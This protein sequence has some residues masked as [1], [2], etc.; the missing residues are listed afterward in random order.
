MAAVQYGVQGS[1]GG[2]GVQ[3]GA[4]LACIDQQLGDG[5]EAHVGH[6]WKA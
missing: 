4:N 5:V 1:A 3:I 2:V 6:P